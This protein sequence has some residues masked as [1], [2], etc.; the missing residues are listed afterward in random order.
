MPDFR[1]LSGPKLPPASGRAA[2]H[3]VV[4]LHGLGADGSDLIGLAPEWARDLPGSEFVSPDAPEPCDMAAMGRQWFSLQ[5]RAPEAILAGVQ[6]AAPVLDVFL[7]RELGRLGLGDD[8]LALVGFSQGTMMA[9][10]VGLRRHRAPA[11]II[12]YSGALVGA[13][14]MREEVRASPPIL[15]V[16]GDRDEVIPYAGLFEA[17][18]LLAAAGMTVEWHIATGIGH[19]IGPTGLEL[20]GQFLAGAFASDRASA[21]QETSA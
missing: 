17:L 16:H 18:P 12:G 8:R 13:H 10:H 4:L 11:A 21:L 2:T 5:N 19:A 9:L 7:D 3:L 6:R 1:E 15:L 14:L 20:G